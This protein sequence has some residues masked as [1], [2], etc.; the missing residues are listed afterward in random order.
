MLKTTLKIAAL[1]AVSL[2]LLSACGASGLINEIN[3]AL[4]AANSNTDDGRPTLKTNTPVS[5]VA[6]TPVLPVP[7]GQTLA[8]ADRIASLNITGRYGL[9][10]NA[11]KSTLG[12]STYT[13]PVTYSQVNDTFALKENN[14]GNLV[15]TVNGTDYIFIA[16]AN[17]PYVSPDPGKWHGS[18]VVFQAQSAD[19]EEPTTYTWNAAGA[20]HLYQATAHGNAHT[21]FRDVLKGE[22]DVHGT[23]VF[24]STLDRSSFDAN[25]IDLDYTEGY[26]TIG[27]KTLPSAVASQTATA[28]Y[29]GIAELQKPAT[30]VVGR[31][32][33]YSDDQFFNSP[34][35]ILEVDFTGNTVEGLMAFHS[36]FFDAYLNHNTHSIIT[37]NSAPIDG[38][39]F[40][41]TFSMN[42]NFRNEYGIVDNPTGSY[43]GN[44]F[45][46][47]ADDIAGVMQY[48]GTTADGAAVGVG[49]F[50]ADKMAGDFYESG[51]DTVRHLLE[52]VVQVGDTPP[53]P[54]GNGFFGVDTTQDPAQ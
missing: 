54:R 45:G 12:V 53:K 15:M 6:D 10:A 19:Y 4:N 20:G 49:G 24:Y 1:S 39:G 23:Y 17:T 16:T 37:L 14:E 51:S 27:V 21:D 2:T 28:Y 5:P 7:E 44:F 48:N 31:G 52:T 18:T 30:Q 9:D 41:G 42:S 32:F 26:A 22:G 34:Q 46:P 40:A 36:S 35:I 3:N 8:V 47:N 13:A 43:A 50:R 29:R 11:P 25:S 33:E 38:N